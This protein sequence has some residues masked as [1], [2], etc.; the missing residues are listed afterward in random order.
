MT[1]LTLKLLFTLACTEHSFAA[2]EQHSYFDGSRIITFKFDPEQEVLASDKDAP[3]SATAQL[4]TTLFEAQGWRL[5]PRNKDKLSTQSLGIP[6][7]F[8]SDSGLAPAILTDEIVV[9]WLPNA[10][11]QGI[12]DWPWLALCREA[13]WKKLPLLHETYLL[14]FAAPEQ[15]LICLRRLENKA[16]IGSLTPNFRM[17]LEARQGFANFDPLV[18]KQWHLK[19]LGQSGGMPGSDAKILEAWELE[20]GANHPLIAVLDLGFEREHPELNP[21]WHTNSD[22]I[23][24]NKR[25]DDANGLIDDVSG[26]NFSIDGPNILYGQSPNHGTAAA[27]IIA[28]IEDGRGTTG[29]CPGCRLLPI[30]VDGRPAQDAMAILY[31]AQQG[32]VVLTNSWGYKIGTPQTKVISDALSKVAREGRK[33]LGIPILFA[34]NNAAI[35]AC[36]GENPDISSHPDVIAVSS[37]DASDVKV[38]ASAY[39]PCLKFVAPSAPYPSGPAGIVTTD[40]LGAKGY[41]TGTDSTNLSELDYTNNF[42]GTSAAT[43]VVAGIFGLLASQ[44]PG[45]SSAAWLQRLVLS[46]DKVQANSAAYNAAGHSNTYGYGRVNARKA[47]E[48]KSPVLT[49]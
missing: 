2:W 33:N 8:D 35:N 17:A 40:R 27:G 5:A 3:S 41:N 25:D 30:V 19:N 28:A 48:I 43:P 42:S 45:E 18:A 23:P 26:W 29:V 38:P 14:T 47:L 22:E 7:L 36:R 24:G 21:Q 11:S 31:A 12:N 15:A 37:V 1:Y 4:T 6:V 16:Q 9:E 10:L 39:G 44:A 49:D 32:A 20:K 46:A 34:M 13:Q